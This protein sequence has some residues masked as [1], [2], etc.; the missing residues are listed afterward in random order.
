MPRRTKLLLTLLLTLLVVTAGCS[1][2]SNTGAS[3]GADGGDASYDQATAASGGDGGSG[4]GGDEAAQAEDASTASQSGSVARRELIRTGEVR[5]RVDDFDAA[6]SNLTA[7]VEARGGYV[8]DTSQEV[9]GYDNQTWTAGTLV[10]RVPNEN[11]SAFFERVKAE[12][13]VQHSE[14]GTEDVTDRV[15]DLEARL[16]NLRAERDRLRTLYDRANETEDVLA[17]G[18]ELSDTQ[19]EIERLEAQLRTLEG[20]VAY[21]TVT[22][23]LT[24]PEPEYEPPERAAWYDTSAV[25]AFLESVDGVVTVAR[26]AFVGAAYAAPYVLV[27]GLPLAGAAVIIRRRRLL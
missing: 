2:G 1:A 17:V 24:E 21:S 4:T 18:R 10:L 27:F 9:R 6:E 7:A 19:E 3:G 20:R 13:E 23:H 5:L 26:A 16:T 8:S 15:V 22:V 25:T 12:G 11:F 14:T